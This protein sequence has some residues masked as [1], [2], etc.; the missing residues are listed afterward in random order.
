MS[1]RHDL[2][3]MLLAAIAEASNDFH[4]PPTVVVTILI[5]QYQETGSPCPR[6]Q[7]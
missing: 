4:L 1:R 3:Q 5:N 6:K 2:V 7:E